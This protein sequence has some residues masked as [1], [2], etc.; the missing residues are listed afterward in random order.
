MI[1]QFLKRMNIKSETDTPPINVTTEMKDASKEFL[2]KILELSNMESEVKL[3][4]D[5]NDTIHLEI[6]NTNQTAYIIGKDGQT[7]ISF[8]HLLKAMLFK[9]FQQFLP[10]F[11][12]CNDYMS[13]KLEKAEEK[14]RKT[15][16]VVYDD[17]CNKLSI[18]DLMLK[19]ARNFI[20]K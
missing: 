14:A 2:E 1:N 6:I 5:L 11:I 13:K 12:D 16:K 17:I 19:N 8:Q 7:L 15:G 18:M 3:N 10:I 9:K 20:I 4:M